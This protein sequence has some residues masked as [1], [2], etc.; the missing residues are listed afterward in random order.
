VFGTQI[1]DGQRIRNTIGIESMSLIPDDDE[2]A[3]GIF[4]A[5]ADMNQLTSIHAISVEHRVIYGLPKRKFNE[6][7]LSSNTTGSSDEIHEP[8]RER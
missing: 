3:L 2:H 5:A 4:A 1:F 6:L 8:V 7:L